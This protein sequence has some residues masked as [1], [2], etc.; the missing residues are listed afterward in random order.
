M[1]ETQLIELLND[2]SLEEKVMQ[3]VQAP[4]GLFDD[5]AAITGI[6]DVNN[7]NAIKYKIGSTLSIW[8]EE[9][10]KK[11][12]QEY[13]EKQPHHIPILFML[14]VI[15]GHKTVFPCPLAQ[16]ATF[17]PEL[18]KEG[19]QAAALESAADGIHVTFSPMADLS[20]DARWGRVME[21]TGEDPYLNGIMAAAMTE[22]YQGEL[23]DNAIDENHVAACVKH[24]AAYG[25]AVA[26]RDYNNVELSEYA[27]RDQYLPAYQ[28]AID[29]GA[30]MVMTSFNTLDGIPSSGNK[31]LMNEIL[32][33]D[34]GFDGV[35]ISDW[36]AVGEMVNHG[37][38]QDL[39]DAAYKGIKAG[40]DIDM[41]S[42]SYPKNLEKLVNDGM[43]SMEELDKCV[44]RVL[45]LKN[46]LGLFENPNRSSKEKADSVLLCE[47]H[48][49]LARK[50]VAKSLV[51]LKNDEEILPLKADKIAFIGP[52]IEGEDI[53]SA[54]SVS[55]DDKDNVSIREG[56]VKAF[57]GSGTEI[58]FAK[59]CT[60]LDNDSLLTRDSFH[61]DNWEETN[62]ELLEEALETAKW[63]DVVVMCLGEHT[64]QS[65]ECTSR[66]N[67][68]L[69]L[70]QQKLLNA[71]AEVNSN[72]V[73]LIMEGRPIE[74]GMVCELSKAVM[75]TWFPGT[76]GGNG[77]LDVI[78]GRALPEGRLPMSFPHS[79][80]QEPLNY[81]SFKTGR[82]K[83]A[84]GNG[85]FTS[86]YLDSPN[87][88]L[89]AF[90]YGLT[91]TTFEYSEVS[92][93]KSQMSSQDKITATARI[94][95][96]GKCEGTETVQL[97]LCDVSGSRVRPVKELKGFKKVSLKAGEEATVSFEI[98][99]AMLRFWTDEN[100][101]ASEKGQFICYIGPDSATTNSALFE[102]R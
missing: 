3:L 50:A 49:A 42:D 6:A 9:K 12:Q 65:G 19:A 2:M 53:R 22:G 51:L 77:I 33:K 82:P 34:M 31:R 71:V 101:F 1:K 7:S 72:I 90:G 96:T 81:N 5:N 36:G 98:C 16:G 69:S 25:G 58:R 47:K 35:L 89:F 70:I 67:I 28:K 80:G 73:S 40:V 29:A 97:Y 84:T 66:T 39:S 45:K 48:R 83:P 61:I 17:D 92:L 99:E 74:L 23:K 79:V 68:T 93:D 43:I 94:K 85:D 91:Y 21:S 4:G 59:G 62:A 8:G 54:W 88:P 102:L 76:E 46:E 57:E 20:R 11:I 56:A 24:F 75:I 78:T 15:N 10:L 60:V 86:R 55:T 41:C 38:A 95:N 87:T 13:M 37:Y 52:Y 32:R 64:F 18:V 44:Y 30:K 27:L 100:K 63:A 14:D 26:G